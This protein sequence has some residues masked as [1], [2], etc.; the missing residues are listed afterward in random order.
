MR[1]DDQVRPAAELV[2]RRGR[3]GERL[4]V[5]AVAVLDGLDAAALVGAGNDGDGTGLVARR[6]AI[7]AVDLRDVV[8]VDLDRDPAERP[9][10]GGIRGGVP[11]EHGL[12]ALAEPVHVD[13]QHEVV[14][15][16]GGRPGQ[17][18]P[19]RALGHL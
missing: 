17:R 7:G 19:H 14:Q 4:A 5:E 8:A 11:A 13:D 3:I 18:L 1:R 12:A 6:L 15:P 2:D 16:R 10:A 9:G